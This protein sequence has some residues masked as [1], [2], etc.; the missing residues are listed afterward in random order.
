MLAV[1]VQNGAGACSA[2]RQLHLPRTL[3]AEAGE[4]HKQSIPVKLQDNLA[5]DGA[6]KDTLLHIRHV[7]GEVGEVGIRT[8][9]ARHTRRTVE[10][11]AEAEAGGDIRA[12]H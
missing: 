10:Q 11:E 7:V 6:E 4:V 12:D 3:W 8:Q 1:A 9:A 2:G 5:K